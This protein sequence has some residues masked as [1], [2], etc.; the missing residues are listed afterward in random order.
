[1]HSLTLTR[2][3]APKLPH[4]K[5][6]STDCRCL[7]SVKRHRRV[8]CDTENLQV[9]G[10]FYVRPSNSGVGR[11]AGYGKALSSA[12][13]SSDRLVWVDEEPIIPEPVLETAGAQRTVLTAIKT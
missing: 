7:L 1:V 13:Q 8:K 11:P 9:V 6:T 4:M 2:Q 3:R 5:V 12:E 10:H